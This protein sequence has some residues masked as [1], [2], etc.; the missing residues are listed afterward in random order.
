MELL[1]SFNLNPLRIYTVPKRIKNKKG[2]STFSAKHI[3]SYL[4]YSVDFSNQLSDREVIIKGKVLCNRAELKVNSSFFRQQY[5]TAWISDGKENCSFYLT[6]VVQ[7]NKGNEFFQDIILPT[8]GRFTDKTNSDHKVIALVK[9][10]HAPN[11][12]PPFNAL[13][14]DG[15]YLINKKNSYIMV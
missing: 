9:T 12:R 5:L 6:F 1:S 15:R 14:I 7:T 8:Y 3:A 10:S 4:D 2:I 11:Y 13:A